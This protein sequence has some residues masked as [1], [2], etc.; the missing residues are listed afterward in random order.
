MW[1]AGMSEQAMERKEKEKEDDRD[2][3]GKWPATGKG[4]IRMSE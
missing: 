3:E 1:M 4:R 2:R